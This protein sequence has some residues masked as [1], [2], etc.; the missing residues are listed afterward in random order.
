[1]TRVLTHHVNVRNPKG[2]VVTFE[3]GADLPKWAAEVLIAE[4]HAA[5]P[6][7]DKRANA[8]VKQWQASKLAAEAAAE[9]GA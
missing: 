4:N 8:L 1:M 6:V 9:M 5:Y 3:P 2:D 7:A